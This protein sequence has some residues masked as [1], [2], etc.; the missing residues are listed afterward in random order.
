MVIHKIIVVIPTH[1]KLSVQTQDQPQHMD[2]L[3]MGCPQ[4][5]PID[6]TWIHWAQEHLRGLLFQGGADT[7]ID[8]VLLT[9]LC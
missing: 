2:T 7:G 9:S 8:N 6:G 5:N 1:S 4:S 3:S